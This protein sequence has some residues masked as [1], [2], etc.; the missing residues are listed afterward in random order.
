MTTK[1]LIHILN[2]FDT[3]KNIKVRMFDERH[4]CIWEIKIN[5]LDIINWLNENYIDILI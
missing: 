4:D 3:D 1:E 5:S 2:L